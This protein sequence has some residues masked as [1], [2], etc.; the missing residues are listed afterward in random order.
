MT[1]AAQA[2]LFD[3]N[4][5]ASVPA[6]SD[7]EQTLLSR[8]RAA[9]LAGGAAP[10]T[11]GAE[12]SQLRT[13][14]RDLIG[15]GFARSLLDVLRDP[16]LAAHSLLQPL[17]PCSR[18]TLE[19]RLRAVHRLLQL[20]VP[21]S[22]GRH[23]IEI[24]DAALPPRTSRGWHDAGVRISGTRAHAAGRATLEPNALRQIFEVAEHDSAEAAALAGL[25]CFTALPL[26]A[27]CELR[28]RDLT[29]GTDR[30]D[31]TVSIGDGT[32]RL[33]FFVTGRASGALIRMYIGAGAG[34]SSYIFQGRAAETP[35]TSRAARDRLAKW[36]TTA[37]QAGV[38][39]YGLVSALA[40]SLRADGLDDASIQLVLGRRKTR[41]VDRLLK[42]HDRLASQRRVQASLAARLAVR[43]DDAS[44]D[45]EGDLAVANWLD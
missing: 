20:E 24:L 31:C 23:R 15:S 1:D 12:L 8:F 35:I 7:D 11:I 19:T 38:T 18:P 22:V 45:G 21:P 13:I 34:S 30:L 14:R 33:D 37:G 2:R 16:A 27:I 40:E 3:F 44:I 39:R 9:R 43:S 28:W 6:P 29:W 42:P 25:L 17:K 26:N 5:A 36:A 4:D 41:T 10:T 32:D